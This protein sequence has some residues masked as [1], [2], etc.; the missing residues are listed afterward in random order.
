MNNKKKVDSTLH[1]EANYT[2]L[3]VDDETL[4]KMFLEKY[5]YEDSEE[6][7]KIL[8]FKKVNHRS[9]IVDLISSYT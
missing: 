3:V 8:E 4:Y 1:L 7:R 9:E 5:G 6:S 2:A